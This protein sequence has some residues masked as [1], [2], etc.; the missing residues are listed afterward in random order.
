MVLF[1]LCKLL[2]G[3]VRVTKKQ[4]V[5]YCLLLSLLVYFL[6]WR[7]A[8]LKVDT[9]PLPLSQEAESGSEVRDIGVG[10]VEE[11]QQRL[12][13]ETS[14][15]A[16]LVWGDS[17]GSAWRRAEFAHRSVRTG[18]LTLAVGP[19]GHFLR[20]FLSSAELYFLPGNTVVYY[21][22]TDSPRNL[23]PPTPLGPGRELRVV[24]VAEMPG[25]ER[26]AQ[27]R[28]A[29]LAATIKE[30]VRHEVEY[31]FC[32]DV[33]QELVA[34]VGAEIL[35][36]LVAALHPE[37][38]GIPRHSFPYEREPASLAHVEEDE[39]DYYYTSELY[40]GLCAEVYA[41]AQACSQL[42]L[43]DQEKGLRARGLEESYLNRYLINRR[44]TCVLS[45]EYSWWDSALAADVPTR[46]V[47]SLGRQCDTLEPQK[48]QEQN[49]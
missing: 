8:V 19:Y 33:D 46:R 43:Q 17:D 4:L 35:G 25:W 24:P 40:G 7:R 23:D 2:S 15:G 1:P 10:S 21:V 38:Y 32:M 20:R 14:W 45:P 16:P 34:P 26:L 39:G 31:V 48:R 12:P 37:L 18:L 44:P 49:C 41:M 6:R 3:S 11:Q 27:G 36:E 28:M 5:L 30:P 47:V 22:L 9:H 13:L 29:L 42:I